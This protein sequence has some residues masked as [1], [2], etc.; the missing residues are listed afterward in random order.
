MEEGNTAEEMGGD[1]EDRGK[2]CERSKTQDA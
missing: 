2:L 1:C